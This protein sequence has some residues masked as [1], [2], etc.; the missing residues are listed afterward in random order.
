V[1]HA[2]VLTQFPLAQTWP[3]AQW[4]FWVQTTR[5][6]PMARLQAKGMQGVTS[7]QVVILTHFPEAS[8]TYPVA[9]WEF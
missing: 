3:V 1:V 4:E 9:Q 6:W 8:Q 5:H 7:E 2:V